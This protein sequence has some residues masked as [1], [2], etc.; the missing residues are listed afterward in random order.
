MSYQGILLIVWIIGWIISIIFCVRF[1]LHEFGQL[2]ISNC[3]IILGVGAFSWIIIF[4][5]LFIKYG[6]IVVI[7]KKQYGNQDEI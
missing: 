1:A 2:T 5:L 3:L 4:M 6:D 7:K